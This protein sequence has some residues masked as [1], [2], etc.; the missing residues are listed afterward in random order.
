MG[1]AVGQ[2]KRK[3]DGVLKGRWVGEA[4][5]CRSHGKEKGSGDADAFE[6]RAHTANRAGFPNSSK[7]GRPTNAHQVGLQEQEQTLDTRCVFGVA[8]SSR[9][10]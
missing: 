1:V 4:R 7:R 2:T 6:Q 8:A 3:V 9:L 10:V 5:D